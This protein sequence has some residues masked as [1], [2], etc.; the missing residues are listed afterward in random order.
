MTWYH[1]GTA[2][3][4]HVL[5]ACLCCVFIS[6]RLKAAFALPVAVMIVVPDLTTL[7]AV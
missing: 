4:D 1:T 5:S 7:E 3:G 6:Q 2:Q